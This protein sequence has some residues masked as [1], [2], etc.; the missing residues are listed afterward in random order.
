MEKAQAESK[1]HSK[2]LREKREETFK[3]SEEVSDEEITI[4]TQL[5]VSTAEG[6]ESP[7]TEGQTH[8]SVKQDI[9]THGVSFVL[10]Q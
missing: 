5:I 8:R 3:N 10:Q 1:G 4:T 2:L 7:H 9:A 6:V